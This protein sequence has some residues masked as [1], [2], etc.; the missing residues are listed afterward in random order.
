MWL[1][2]ND[3]FSCDS[4]SASRGRRKTTHY[5]QRHTPIEDATI[6][7]RNTT[8]HLLEH[9]PQ[10]LSDTKLLVSLLDTLPDLLNTAERILRSVRGLSGLYHLN[11]DSLLKIDGIDDFA[12]ARLLAAVEITQRIMRVI[13]DPPPR[14]SSADD[15]MDY[16]HD[17]RHL[18]QEHVRVLLDSQ[19]LVAAGKLLDI[20]PVDHIIISPLGWTSL[21]RSGF[22]FENA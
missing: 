3:W 10:G 7:K 9:G 5:W 19:D 1:H 22:G 12:R 15:A 20:R 17:M 14:I 21:R 4:I 6:T 18:T 2:E 13:P 16:L 8:A 11:P